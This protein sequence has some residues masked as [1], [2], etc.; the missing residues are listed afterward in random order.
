MVWALLAFLGIPL[1]L[2]A[3]G[4]TA[5]FWNRHAVVDTPWVFPCKLRAISGDPPGLG[6]KFPR[7]SNYGL[8]V[9]DVLLVKG[10]LPLVKTNHYAVASVERQVEAANP[11]DWKRLGDAPRL[12]TLRLDDDSVIEVAASRENE[13][14][15]ADPFSLSRRQED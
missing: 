4:L 1:W 6:S 12:L 5:T 14:L 15:L 9:H 8:W 7:F 2:I 13:Q 11:D 3:I 10:G